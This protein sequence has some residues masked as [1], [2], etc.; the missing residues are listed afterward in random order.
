MRSPRGSGCPAWRSRSHGQVRLRKEGGLS[1]MS[2]TSISTRNSSKGSPRGPPGAGRRTGSCRFA[3]GQSSHS[4]NTGLQVEV[5]MGVRGWAP[6]ESLRE[7][8]FCNVKPRSSAIF[9]TKVPCFYS[10][11]T[12]VMKLERT[13]STIRA[14]QR[15]IAQSS[16][17]RKQ[18]PTAS[19][20]PITSPTTT[21][22]K[23]ISKNTN[24]SAL[25]GGLLWLS[26]FIQ[27]LFLFSLF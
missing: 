9:P 2:S 11:C 24:K 26:D 7:R 8:K 13:P 19:Q 6:F 22:K 16:Q 27:I 17:E 10:S 21:K 4:Y 20:P 25:C 14:R 5:Q 15:I 1:L 3:R 18:L 12:R 23:K